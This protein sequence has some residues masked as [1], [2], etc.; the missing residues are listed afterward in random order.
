MRRFLRVTAITLAFLVA[1]A[2]LWTGVTAL[3]LKGSLPRLSG[4]LTVDGPKSPVRIVR[5]KE[6]VPHIFAGSRNDALFGLGYVHAQDRLWQMEFQRRAVQGRLSEVAGSAALV[7]DTYLRTL[8]LYRSAEQSI[9]ALSPEARLA[10]DAYTAGVNAAIPRHGKPLPP[11]FFMLGVSAEDWKP[12]HSLAVLKAISV[13]LSANAFQEILRLQLLG[14]MPPE[15]IRGLNPPLPP[16]VLDAYRQYAPQQGTKFAEAAR[17]L[18]ALAPTLDPT[19]ASNNWVVGGARTQS[20][21]PMLANDPHLPLTVPGFWYLAHLNWPGGF[22]IG[23]SVPGV[24][25]IVSGRTGKIAWGLT[26][27]GADTQDLFWEKIDPE[28]PARYMTPE[29]SAPFESRREVIKV[30][31]GADKS[32]R[33]L[34]TRHGPVLPTDEPRLKA[35]VPDGFALSLQWPALSGEDR[36]METLLHIL[37]A[38]DASPASIERTFAP[39]NAPI[40]SFVYADI[41]GN[42][43]LILPGRIPVR[44]PA[45]VVTGL[46]PSDG[47]NAMHDWKGFL[48]GADRPAWA[49]GANDAFVTANNNV[50]PPGYKPMI[51]LDFDP[52]Y[53]AMRIK[54]LLG[55]PDRKH[56]VDSFRQIQLDDQERFA[57]DALPRLL[58]MVDAGNEDLGKIVAA[59]GQWDHRMEISKSEPLIFAGW[60]RQLLKNLFEDEAGDLFR[61]MWGD[62]PTLLAAI[63]AG[64]GNASLLCDD[65]R[66]EK[67]KEDC[68]TVVTKSLS[69]ALTDLKSRHGQDMKAW[70]WG[71]AH[72][73]T[74]SHTPF[75]FVPVLSSLFGFSHEMGGGNSTIQRAAYR[76]SNSNPFAAVHGSGYRAIYDL[77]AEEKSLYMAST[78][79]SGNVYSP[80]YDNLA[81]RWAKGEYLPLKTNRE[82]IEAGAAGIL[83]LRPPE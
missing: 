26:T 21:L 19:G 79:Q 42:T 50:V 18:Q 35:L 81:P 31:L 39:Y 67:V 28:N 65:I 38:E 70:R 68:R 13:Q 69:E 32:I 54:E 41:K 20:G 15:K 48:A 6:G 33:I 24:P 1:L 60:M 58:A 25:G 51:A 44:D 29:G 82:E 23:G 30:R 37:D 61:Q 63:A 46:L 22:A 76:Y 4:E 71:D 7:A 8:G 73:A 45:N 5:D 16:E 55:G 75:G 56:D 12:A 83:V 72:R 14:R 40:Q 64:D 11:E 66:T 52:E 80:Y 57:V 47:T 59:L 2:A 43:G 9:A 78:G 36:T 53:R 77:G 3:W 34:S 62:R 10:L 27:T 49:G 17:A 74:F